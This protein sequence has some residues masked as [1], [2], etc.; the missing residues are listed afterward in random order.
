MSLSFFVPRQAKI[1]DV[2]ALVGTTP[3]AI[4]HYH[5]TRPIPMSCPGCTATAGRTTTW[6]GTTRTG[7][8]PCTVI[9]TV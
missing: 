1:G 9:A 2:A 6:A 7:H 3:R 8:R 5:A 4:R